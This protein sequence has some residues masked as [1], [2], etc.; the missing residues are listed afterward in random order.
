MNF[1]GIS[2][3]RSLRTKV[4]F[5]SFVLTTFL[6]YMK[7]ITNTNGNESNIHSYNQ[8]LIADDI[9]NIEDQQPIA[10]YEDVMA[11]SAKLY[12]QYVDADIAKQIKGLG[13]KGQAASLKNAVSKEI[14]ERQLKKIALNEEL[15]EHI[16]YNRTLA[17]ARN[18]LCRLHKINLNELPT[19]SVIIIFYNVIC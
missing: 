1:F 15:S 8:K 17:D 10:V 11:H 3:R 5:L 7:F 16:S 12:K 14:G 6:L 9:N 18:P 4:F 19:T 13:D 2:V